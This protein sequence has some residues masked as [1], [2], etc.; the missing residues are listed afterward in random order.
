[1]LKKKMKFEKR[2]NHLFT[3]LLM[4][5]SLSLLPMW[6]VAESV[7]INI[8]APSYYSLCAFTS[9]KSFCKINV[10]EPFMDQDGRNRIFTAS[11]GTVTFNTDYRNLV[12]IASLDE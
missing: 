1:M 4:A 9:D 6:G 8:S 3:P 7:A 10:D 2:T 11:T 12:P 5:G